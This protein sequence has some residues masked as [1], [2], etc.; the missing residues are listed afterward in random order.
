M[1]VC[2]LKS[3][4]CVL[5]YKVDKSLRW[6]ANK[7][8]ITETELWAASSTSIDCLNVSFRDV[9]CLVCAPTKVRE[10]FKRWSLESYSVRLARL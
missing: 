5:Y 2:P 10:A 7:N 1:C 3:D 6:Y 4:V 8:M 9:S